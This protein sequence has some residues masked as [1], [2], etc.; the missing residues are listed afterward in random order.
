MRRDITSLP[1]VRQF[2][3]FASASGTLRDRIRGYSG[4]KSKVHYVRDVPFA[5]LPLLAS[6]LWEMRA[7]IRT[8]P[9][10]QIFALAR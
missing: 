9:L 5:P 3:Y 7:R 8:T 4:V 2:K 1:L 10:P 6:S